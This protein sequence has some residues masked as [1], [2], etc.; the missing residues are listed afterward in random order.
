MQRFS[1]QHS[2]SRFVVK[3]FQWDCAE[4]SSAKSVLATAMG[5]GALHNKT[6]LSITT[7]FWPYLAFK[8]PCSVQFPDD[9]TI[10][11]TLPLMIQGLRILTRSF[12]CSS[13]RCC[14]ARMGCRWFSRNPIPIRT[15]AVKTAWH[16]QL[17]LSIT[18]ESPLHE[19][20]MRKK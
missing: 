12:C 19:T 8:V 11:G 3:Y 18:S 13:P 2:E 14:W 17:S 6:L 9:L 5:F 15:R 20:I 16:A 1:I 4:Y 10:H 7:N